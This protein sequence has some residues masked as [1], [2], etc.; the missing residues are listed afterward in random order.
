MLSSLGSI[1]NIGAIV[2]SI[3]FFKKIFF[4]FPDFLGLDIK[5]EVA[6]SMAK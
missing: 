2:T 1:I 6:E 5:C 4:Y 3:L